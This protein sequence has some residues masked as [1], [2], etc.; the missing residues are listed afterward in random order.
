ML[1]SN[2]PIVKCSHCKKI[3]SIENFDS[4]KC[5]LPITDVRHIPVVYFQDDSVNGR[6]LMTGRGIDGILYTFEVVPREPIPYIIPLSDGFLQRKKPDDN[7]TEPFVVRFISYCYSFMALV[8][9]TT[10]KNIRRPAFS[11]W[12]T[13]SPTGGNPQFGKKPP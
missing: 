8:P 7:L 9:K 2:S 4:H 6:Q 11:G 1:K 3:L 13:P 12:M 10:K 5:S